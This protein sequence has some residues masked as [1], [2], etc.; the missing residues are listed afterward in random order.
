VEYSLTPMGMEVA[1]RVAALVDWI[2]TNLP[3]VMET[4]KQLAAQQ[5]D[6]V[7]GRS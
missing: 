5:D 6:T 2:E 4:R 7:V 3:R 1:E